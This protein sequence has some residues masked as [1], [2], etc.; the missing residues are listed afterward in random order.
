V[1]FGAGI[2]RL[3]LAMEAEGLADV[4][5]PEIDVFLAFQDDAPR[6]RIAAWLAELSETLRAGRVVRALRRNLS[7]LPRER[8]R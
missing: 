5:A 8:R 6:D 2:E 3:I 7:A 4:A 1:G